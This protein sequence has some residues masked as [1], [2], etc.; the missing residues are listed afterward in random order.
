MTNKKPKTH[1]TDRTHRT[2]R[3]DRTA[4]IPVRIKDTK[5][6]EPKPEPKPE[7][8]VPPKLQSFKKP[9]QTLQAT[10]TP[11]L[12]QTPQATQIVKSL[13]PTGLLGCKKGAIDHRDYVLS[14]P[15]KTEVLKAVSGVDLRATCPAIYDQGQLGSCVSNGVAFTIQFGQNKFNMSHKFNP[16][17][18]FIY[19]NT[20]V[21]EQSV[22]EDSGTTVRGA[23]Q[24]VNKQGACPETMWP[25]VVS[26]F[27]TR[28]SAEAYTSGAQHLVKTYS[29]VIFD[30]GQMKQCLIDGYP[31]VFGM[32]LYSSF[33]NVTSNGMVS[34]PKTNEELLG[35]HC[36]SCVGY[37]DNKQC[38]IV[39][40]SWGPTWGDNGVCYIPYSYMCDANN[41]WDLWTVREITDTEGNVVVVT[42]NLVNIKQVMYGKNNKFIDVTT[43]F[44]NYFNSGNTSMVVSNTL[45]TDP[46]RGVRKELRIIYNNGSIMTYSEGST[47]KITDLT[48]SSSVI[49][50]SNIKSAIY[51]KGTKTVDVTT[52]V[53]NNFSQGYPQ[54]TVNNTLFTDP[55]V[56]VRKEL[57]LTLTN[58]VVKVFP[59]GSIVKITDI[60]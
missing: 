60:N 12:P 2:H 18:L 26:Q 37:D 11:Q 51:G 30:I 13:K 25:Y 16:S 50:T 35:G 9:P 44:K 53:K 8:N 40:N 54:L 46:I 7:P 15:I 58:D 5:V 39:R 23:M 49:K 20:R 45:F 33:Y 42:D 28:P 3:T 22:N 43:K 17:R 27:K 32:L 6:P 24:A 1:R 36:M 38:F 57:R 59:E 56:G 47:I 31:F 19:Y 14:L 4:K 52:I 34:V 55:C 29:R 41:T 48:V 21:I 10:Q